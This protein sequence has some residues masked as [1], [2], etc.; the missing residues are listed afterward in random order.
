MGAPR[1]DV[2]G[3]RLVHSLKRDMRV[4]A[5]GRR[6]GSAHY[7]PLAGLVGETIANAKL[8]RQDLGDDRLVLLPGPRSRHGLVE[9]PRAP[10]LTPHRQRPPEL[11]AD[12]GPR[13]RAP[14]RLQHPAQ[15]A[16]DSGARG[17]RDGR[18]VSFIVPFGPSPAILLDRAVLLL[19]TR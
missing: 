11:D 19:R 10:D 18:L 6:E 7:F 8:H 4:L 12:H 15:D 5:V 13:L 9:P 2:G 1:P 3:A 14:A 17:A 16:A